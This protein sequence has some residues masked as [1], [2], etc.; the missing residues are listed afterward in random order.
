MTCLEEFR[1]TRVALM[2][3]AAAGM[4]CRPNVRRVLYKRPLQTH[5]FR[6]ATRRNASPAIGVYAVQGVQNLLGGWVGLRR[7]SQIQQ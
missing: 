7:Q 3:S 5:A 4:V 2:H 1:S 6:A